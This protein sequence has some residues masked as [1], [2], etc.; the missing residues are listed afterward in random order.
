MAAFMNLVGSEGNE[1][2]FSGQT[3]PHVEQ[4]NTQFPLFST[5]NCLLDLVN[6]NTAAPH[7]SKHNPQLVQS[8]SSIEGFQLKLS[9]WI[10]YHSLFAIVMPPCSNLM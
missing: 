5:E 6:P 2:A 10:P 4:P 1:I 8:A 9:L 7:D 3:L